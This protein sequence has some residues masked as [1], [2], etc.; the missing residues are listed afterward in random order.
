MEGSVRRAGNRIRVTAQL[1]A[2]ADGSNLWSER[3]D[4]QLDDVFEVQDEIARAIAGMLEAKLSQSG[5]EEARYVPNAAAY[6]ALLKARHFN[7]QLS[8][9]GLAQAD[10]YHQQAIALDPRYADAHAGYAES[11]FTRVQQGMLPAHEGMPR[12]RAEA[13]KALELDPSLVEAHALLAG[14]AALYEYDWE[15]AERQYRKAAAGQALS[16]S[17]RSF[18]SLWVLRLMGRFDEA[19]AQARLAAQ[20]DPLNPVVQGTLAFALMATGRL[21][22]AEEQFRHMLQLAPGYLVA[23]G[24]TAVFFASQGQF[25]EAQAW[26]EKAYPLAPEA[27][28]LVGSLAGAMARNGETARAEELAAQIRGGPAHRVNVGML[29]YYLYSG[30]VERAAEYAERAIEERYTGLAIGL[31]SEFARPLRESVRWPKLAKMMNLPV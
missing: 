3:Y 12:M 30:D 20:G 22:E 29:Y 1:I 7:R 8:A 4:R 6:E 18:C 14:V 21:D 5:S 28:F 23:L 26:L 25:Q 19:L 2:A 17:A 16:P 31:T 10:A 15:E 9:E 27:P 11:L 13:R 24:G